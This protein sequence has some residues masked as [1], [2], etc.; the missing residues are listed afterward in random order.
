MFNV[1]LLDWQSFND[2]DVKVR[3]VIAR[4]ILSLD[5]VVLKSV[6]VYNS[7]NTCRDFLL[8]IGTKVNNFSAL[9]GHRNDGFRIKYKRDVPVCFKKALDLFIKNEVNRE[10]MANNDMTILKYALF[11]FTRLSG[12]QSIHQD[13]TTIR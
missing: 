3:E 12:F 13:Y 11:M 5:W 1:Q 8:Q 2:I 7:N 4:D 9:I 6:D 10:S